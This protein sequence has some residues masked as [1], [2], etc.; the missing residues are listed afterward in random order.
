M[1]EASHFSGELVCKMTRDHPPLSAISL[2]DPC[3]IS[4]IANDFGFDKVFSRQI[5]ALGR[6]GDILITLST[7]GKS[8]NILKAQEV[9]KKLG[10]TVIPFPTNSELDCDT[11]VTQEVHLNMIHSISKIVEDYFIDNN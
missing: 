10:L 1:S 7:S 4:A 8:P 6:K 9:G 11:Q 3:V 2:C 5:T